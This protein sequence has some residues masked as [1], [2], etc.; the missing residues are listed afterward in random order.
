MDAVPSGPGEVV[1]GWSGGMGDQDR[2]QVP[3]VGDGQRDQAG[4]GGVAAFGGGDRGQDRCGEHDQGGVAVPGVPPSDLV[5][6][7]TDGAFRVLEAGFY[8]PSGAG[9]AHEGR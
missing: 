3:D 7:E 5:L 4:L 8:R 9:D 2:E 6:I 1:V